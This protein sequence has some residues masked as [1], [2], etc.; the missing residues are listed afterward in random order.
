MSNPTDD[1][2]WAAYVELTL[3][4]A[5]SD[6]ANKPEIVRLCRAAVAAPTIRD[7]EQILAEAHWGDPDYCAAFLRRRCP[8]RDDTPQP[9]T[10]AVLDECGFEPSD[11]VPLWDMMLERAAVTAEPLTEGWDIVWY[12][13]GDH[14]ELVT[15]ARRLR[16]LCD[17]LR[18][19]Y[20][21]RKEG[22]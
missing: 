19:V 4:A 5:E 10:D 17:G 18:K 22:P 3:G 14:G 16:E 9:I 2:L 1:E 11:R 21:G 20:G 13:E 8:Q 7:A 6:D 12:A 15:D